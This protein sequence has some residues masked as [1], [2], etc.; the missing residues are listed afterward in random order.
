[1]YQV[2]QLAVASPVVDLRVEDFRDLELGLAIDL[3]RQ[4][5]GLYAVRDRVRDGGLELGYMKDWV[6]GPHGFG[7]S[8]GA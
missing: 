1:M 5:W 3:N 8:E 2:Q 6:N 4:G 7:E